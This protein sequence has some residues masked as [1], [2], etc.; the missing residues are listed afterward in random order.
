M[1]A[2]ERRIRRGK[3]AEQYVVDLLTERGCSVLG[4]NFRTRFGEID[5]IALDDSVLVFA[6]VRARTGTSFAIADDTVTRAK[7]TRIMST[8][9]AFIEAHPEFVDSYWRVDLFALTLNT[10]GRVITCRQYE[11]LTLD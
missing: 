7:L 6:E 2:S 10:S 3:E 1:S 5:I 8:A 9:Q 11:N 4:R